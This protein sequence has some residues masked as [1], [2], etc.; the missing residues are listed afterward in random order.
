MHA[1]VEQ[2]NCDT[3]ASTAARL[4]FDAIPERKQR[5]TALTA[6]EDSQNFK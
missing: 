3:M 2:R 5:G 4:N 1:A 6:H